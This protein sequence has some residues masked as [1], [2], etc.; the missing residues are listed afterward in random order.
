MIFQLSKSMLGIFLLGVIILPSHLASQESPP[1]ARRAVGHGEPQL[2]SRS[3][4]E[5]G[6]SGNSLPRIFPKNTFTT[7]AQAEAV[8]ESDVQSMDYRSTCQNQF[9]GPLPPK[10]LGVQASCTEDQRNWVVDITLCCPNPCKDLDVRSCQA[11]SSCSWGRCGHV[12]GSLTCSDLTGREQCDRYSGPCNWEQAECVAG[13][14]LP[15]ECNDLNGADCGRHSECKLETEC[16]YKSG[17]LTCAD[18]NQSQCSHYGTWCSWNKGSCRKKV[19]AGPFECRNLSTQDCKVESECSLTENC[20]HQSGSLTCKDL[21]LDEC[22]RYSRWCN[23]KPG[24]CI[25]DPA[26]P[27][28]S[29][30]CRDLQEVDC[31]GETACKW[32]AQCFH[33]SE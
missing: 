4:D 9:G 7:C 28:T 10:V 14:I 21:S 26:K 33:H 13:G 8:C 32:A 22:G 29:F 6:L 2:R 15:F 24:R 16:R 30:T 11:I 19:W 5:G 23:S 20:R 1:V 27:F 17:S 12:K 3:C 31:V 25:K 18:L